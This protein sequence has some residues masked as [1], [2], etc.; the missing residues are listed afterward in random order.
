MASPLDKEDQ[1]KVLLEEH[2]LL[3]AALLGEPFQLG[4]YFTRADLV[5]IMDNIHLYLKTNKRL[6]QPDAKAQE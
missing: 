6:G 5:K 2:R 1:L 4:R 3:L